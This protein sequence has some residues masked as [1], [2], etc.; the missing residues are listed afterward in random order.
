MPHEPTAAESA[1]RAV[2]PFAAFIPVIGPTLPLAL[3]LLATYRQT[4]DAIEGAAPGT[5]GMVS[6]A[7]LIDLL[8]L[9]ATTLRTRASALAAKLAAPEG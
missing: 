6:D 4:R 9:D 8:K 2:A 7:E 5:S 1:L 3:Q